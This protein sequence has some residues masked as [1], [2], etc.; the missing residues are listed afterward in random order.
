MS[1][2]CLHKRPG[3]Q[4]GLVLETHCKRV[5]QDSRPKGLGLGFGSGSV[6]KVA[7]NLKKG[8]ANTRILSRVGFYE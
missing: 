6:A 2:E 5:P 3:G 8:R 7:W 4:V 1:H